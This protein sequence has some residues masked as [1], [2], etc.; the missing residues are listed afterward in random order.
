ML[1]TSHLYEYRGI[2]PVKVLYHTCPVFGVEG[3][4]YQTLF[5]ELLQFQKGQKNHRLSA[6]LVGKTHPI[7][8]GVW[9]AK[10]EN[11]LYLQCK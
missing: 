7:P 1:I 8:R 4:K 2:A 3:K 6:K 10:M 9:L 5:A 11:L